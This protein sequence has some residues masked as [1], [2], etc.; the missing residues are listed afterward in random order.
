MYARLL[1]CFHYFPA[2]FHEQSQRRWKL[3]FF[4]F[5]DE[6]FLIYSSEKTV[7]EDILHLGQIGLAMALGRVKLHLTQKNVLSCK[8]LVCPNEMTKLS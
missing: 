6:N 1:L 4:F 5:P 8:Y 3:F 7:K 2:E